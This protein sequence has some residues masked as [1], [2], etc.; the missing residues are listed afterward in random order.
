[1][2]DG[3]LNVKT[4]FR[5]FLAAF[6]SFI[7]GFIYIPTSYGEELRVLITGSPEVSLEPPE[8]QR[9]LS[10]PYNGSALIFLGEGYRF[11][12]GIE[13]ELSAPQGWLVYR[14]SLAA[15]AY[16][17]LERL[18]VGTPAPGIAIDIAGKRFLYDPLPGKLQI[19]YHIPLNAGHGMRTTPYTL[20]PSTHVP[21]GEFPILFRLM[22][23]VKGISEDLEGMR[24]Q[25]SVKPILGDEGAVRIG[26]RYPVQLPDR[27][28]TL[29]VDDQVIRT[30]AEE[31]LLKE[32]EHHLLILSDD[33]RN[34]N[35]L[36]LVERARILDLSI[37]LQDPTPLILFEAPENSR[38]FLDNVL[39][40]G[41]LT[42]IPVEPGHHEVRFQVSDYS[43]IKN[44]TVQ[45][46]KTYRAA[47]MVDV[48]VSED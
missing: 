31:L 6:F 15:A 41:N 7:F 33:Y 24:F 46:G 3:L 1:M 11:F 47:L 37:E 20:V 35:R 36:F 25:L 42:P 14:G 45:R 21:P 19:V 16:S 13:V 17:D 18:P 27:P 23:V 10:I 30:P 26:F 34:E 38:V 9:P 32:G 5:V 39:V 2:K 8:A 43:I 22:P 44:I 40:E 29:L 12:R 4:V 28:F 48:D